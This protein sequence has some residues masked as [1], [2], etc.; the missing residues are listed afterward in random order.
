MVIVKI[1]LPQKNYYLVQAPVCLS[2]YANFVTLSEYTVAVYKRRL[3]VVVRYD[4]VRYICV[5][6]KT[7]G[8][9]SLI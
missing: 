7:D 6:S 9:A 3:E 2:Q 4:T 1:S 8:R 5:R